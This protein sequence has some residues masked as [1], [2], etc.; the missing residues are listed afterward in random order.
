MMIKKNVWMF[1]ILALLLIGCDKQLSQS[2]TNDR[3]PQPSPIAIGIRFQ[4]QGY[5]MTDMM[6]IPMTTH[7]DKYYYVPSGAQ[8]SFCKSRNN[9]SGECEE[10]VITFEVEANCFQ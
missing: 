2:S 8:V 9:I 5:I 10:K 7:I 3:V 4:E 1:V 6:N